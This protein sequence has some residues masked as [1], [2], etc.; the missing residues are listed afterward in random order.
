MQELSEVTGVKWCV[1]EWCFFG[2]KDGYDCVGVRRP[3]SFS[4]SQSWSSSVVVEKDTTLVVS[5]S[6]SFS[7]GLKFPLLS[8][9]PHQPPLSHHP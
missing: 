7:E 6:I 3:S 9:P 4:D 2:E 8:S 5:S 1:V